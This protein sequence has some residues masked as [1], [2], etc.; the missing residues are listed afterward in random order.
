MFFIFLY[1]ISCGEKTQ[2]TNP[3]IGVVNDHYKIHDCLFTGLTS[4]VIQYAS[5]ADKI[6]TMILVY[7]RQ[8]TAS[9]G[10]LCYIDY[11]NYNIK[12]EHH[13]VAVGTC[14]VNGGK[15]DDAI[16][17]YNP[18]SSSASTLDYYS[19]RIIQGELFR[20]YLSDNNWNTFQFKNSNYS[21]S[22]MSPSDFLI[23][24]RHIK[25]IFKYCQITCVTNQKAQFVIEQS[26][27]CNTNSWCQPINGGSMENCYFA[28]NK[29]TGGWSGVV[30]ISGPQ[31]TVKNSLF[32]NN[33]YHSCYVEYGMLTIQDCYLD[34]NGYAKPEN[35]DYI[36]TITTTGE[37]NTN[38][39]N[40][41]KPK[42]T[43]FA[44]GGVHAEI[45]YPIRSATL[46][47]TRSPTSPPTKTPTPF[48]VQTPE[49][50][51]YQTP[52]I[53]PYQTIGSSPYQTPENTII[54][55]PYTSSIEDFESETSSAKEIE[56]VISSIEEIERETS[57]IEEIEPVISSIEEIEPVISS[58][59]EIQPVI[60]S[61]EEI[62]TQTPSIEGM[63]SVTSSIEEIEGE[64]SSP[65]EMNKESSSVL[66]DNEKTQTVL[67]SCTIL[68]SEISD[69]ET[70]DSI[71]ESNN[72]EGAIEGITNTE[73]NS[74]SNLLIII[75]C[76][77][78]ALFIIIVIA[79]VFIILRRKN[80]EETETNSEAEMDDEAINLT[81]NSPEIATISLFTSTVI[82]ETD[83]FENDFEENMFDLY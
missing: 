77:L 83:P 24:A 54:P 29:L 20:F 38:G 30:Y 10:A 68:Y 3:K 42:M 15:N 41:A 27:K 82:D 13:F 37:V 59:E 64:T 50:T 35:Y 6:L 40:Q 55:E 16:I 78:A 65:E 39:N 74:S 79:I 76:V 71:I 7:A 9:N 73:N 47:P 21:D 4:S 69:K 67:E 60:S 72:N 66:I 17:F 57:S 48:P 34:T 12:F 1:L 11:T 26:S 80:K 23:Y 5:T 14:T 61:I 70:S 49:N 36:R 25:T 45:K 31:F 33:Q 28:N 62:E 2:E 44:T 43:F 51:A 56:P 46:H 53:T 58:I 81:S 32:Q 19:T 75:C 63:E 8:I 52:E 22:N 18:S